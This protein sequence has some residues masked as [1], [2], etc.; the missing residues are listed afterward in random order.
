MKLLLFLPTI[1]IKNQKR[2][3]KEVANLDSSHIVNNH[4]P[5]ARNT[6]SRYTAAAAALAAMVSITQANGHQWEH[7]NHVTMPNR[8]ELNEIANTVLDGD[9]VLKY[10]QLIQ[11][12]TLG[13]Q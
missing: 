10:R 9:K 2:A 7:K 5:P 13:E 11:H 12:P 1:I 3:G 6:R 8:L 4:G